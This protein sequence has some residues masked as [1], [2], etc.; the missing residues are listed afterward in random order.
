MGAEQPAADLYLTGR[1]DGGLA[2][3][4]AALRAIFA[5]LIEVEL[6]RM[7]DEPPD[8]PHFGEPFLW[9]ALFRGQAQRGTR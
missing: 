2:Y 4:P 8:S 5:D 9:T 7:N 3:T 1:L 6:R